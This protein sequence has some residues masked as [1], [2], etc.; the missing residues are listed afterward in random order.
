MEF[1]E[2]HPDIL[3]IEEA[4]EILRISAAEMRELALSGAITYLSIGARTVILKSDLQIFIE[5][6]RHMCYNKNTKAHLEN[7]I[8]TGFMSGSEGETEMAQQIKRTIIIQGKKHWINV[9]GMQEFADKIVE[10]I[11]QQST[12]SIGGHPFEEYAWNWF[13]T[14]SLPNIQTVTA[15]TYQRQLNLYLIPAFKNLA[16]EDITTIMFNVCSTTCPVPKPPRT[17]FEWY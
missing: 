11:T 8:K 15:T 1:L 5:S 10:I 16:V 7:C 4:A 3:R 9:S 17:R 13:Q 2:Q 12:P 14:Y 6:N